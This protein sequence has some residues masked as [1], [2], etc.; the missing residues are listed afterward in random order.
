VPARGLCFQEFEI[1]DVHASGGR[2]VTEADIVAFA[3]ISGDFTP[4][5]TD[6]VFARETPFRGRIAHGM[7]VHAIASGL[8]VQTG[9]FEGTLAAL[10]EM[11]IRFRAPVRPG[12]TI[13]AELR[14]VAKEETPGPRRG[15]VRFA[16]RVVNQEDVAVV[17]GE[18]L[19]LMNLERDAHRRRAARGTGQGS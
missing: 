12:D 2:T 1:D 3:G 10:S 17:E 7:L 4:L 18:W 6:E 11:T 16:L 8:A 13:R 5:H 14:V 15:W 9:I 19:T